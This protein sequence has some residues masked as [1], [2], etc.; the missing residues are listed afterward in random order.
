MSCFWP[1]LSSILR[2]TTAPHAGDLTLDLWELWPL[3][4]RE[5]FSCP[6]G[7]I[8]V[9]NPPEIRSREAK[10]MRDDENSPLPAGYS[11]DLVGDPCI[12]ILCRSD[13]TAVARF[14]HAA[15]PEEIRRAAEEDARA[16]GG[17]PDD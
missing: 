8:T 15:D 13:G 1:F 7:Y 14:T 11:L 9:V 17:R 5:V 2:S 16:R 6:L 12:I 4:T 10:T 3:C